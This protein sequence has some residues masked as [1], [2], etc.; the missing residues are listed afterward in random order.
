MTGDWLDRVEAVLGARPSRVQP[1]AGGSVG[2]VARL[3]FAARPSLVVKR[4]AIHGRL[5]LEGWMLRELAPHLPVP[6]VIH[7]EP[8]LLILTHIEGGGAVSP[9][10]EEHA[11]DLL[12]ALHNVRGSAFGLDRATLIGALPQP[13]DPGPQWVPFFRDRRL[14][15]MG[16]LA[17]KAGN[18]PEGCFA[19]IE[20]LAD[21][22]DQILP[23][24]DYPS[25][26]HGDIWG[27]NVIVAD[28]R[29][30]GFIDPAIYY[31]DP[32]IE[33]A[34]TTMFHTFGPRFFAR[35]REHRP[36]DAGFFEERREIYMLYPLLV[37]AALYGSGYGASADWILRR[38]LGPADT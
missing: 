36:L 29:I 7:A 5:D 28:G 22:L 9:E 38:R 35:Y 15:S 2:T 34:Y 16:R 13:N 12:A 20:K 6:E 32:E 3:D 17:E 33:L 23:E 24:P 21:R 26:I 25:L 37:H 19:R 31:A 10:A 1:L 18:L 30:A 11:A 27:G 14:L 8:G 4:D